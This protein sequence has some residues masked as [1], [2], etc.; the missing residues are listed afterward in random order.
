MTV[1]PP[2]SPRRSRIL[3]L[4]IA[5]PGLPPV[6]SMVVCLCYQRDDLVAPRR[7]ILIFKR[8]I[9]CLT[10]PTSIQLL[11]LR[12]QARGDSIVP[13][14][15]ILSDTHADHCLSDRPPVLTTTARICHACEPLQGHVLRPTSCLGF[16][17]LDRPS[18]APSSLSSSPS[19]LQTFL[20][21]IA[22]TIFLSHRYHRWLSYISLDRSFPTSPSSFPLVLSACLFKLYRHVKSPAP[23]LR[24]KPSPAP[25]FRS[26]DFSLSK[27]HR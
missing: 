2:L 24:V 12:C 23:R 1:Y 13:D 16:L 17:V 20:Q 18:S 25:I 19:T 26:R 10:S 14:G 5:Y 6:H 21:S 27:M 4:I 9:A 8:I 15:T 7:T 11:R 3:K 22:S